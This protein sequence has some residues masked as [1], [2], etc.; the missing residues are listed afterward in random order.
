MQIW[1]PC[2]KKQHHNDVIP[3]TMANNGKMRTSTESHKMY[4]FCK[5]LMRAIQK[6][7]FIEF[8]PLCQKLWAFMSNLPSPLTKYGHV[9]WLWRRIPKK[10][11]FPQILY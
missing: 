5:V 9:M 11:I 7:N 6:C 10:F 4:I 2:A 1:K 3:K 8:E